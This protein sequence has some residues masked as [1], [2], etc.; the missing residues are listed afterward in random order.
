MS[1]FICTQMKI[2]NIYVSHFCWNA[3]VTFA[4]LFL[5]FP[6][7]CGVHSYIFID[8]QMKEVV[9]NLKDD[10]PRLD[11]ILIHMG[12]MYATLNMFEKSLDTYQR[13]VYIMEGTYGENNFQLVMLVL[14]S[15]WFYLPDMKDYG[16]CYVV[17]LICLNE[18]LELFSWDFSVVHV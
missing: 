17:L 1:W 2:E 14:F 18:N 4:H 3:S 5:L 7:L 15:I 13:A 11:S 8:G 9:D 12:S 16:W 6:F 10:A